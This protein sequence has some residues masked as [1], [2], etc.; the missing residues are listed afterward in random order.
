MKHTK[1]ILLL[2]F[3]LI[4]AAPAF[5]Q[6]TCEIERRVDENTG[7]TT[8][9]TSSA[10]RFEFLR[11]HVGAFGDGDVSMVLACQPGMLQM[12]I[13]V[14][15]LEDT[16]L[17][18]NGELRTTVDGDDGPRLRAIGS[19]THEEDGVYIEV[20]AFNL[21]E[22]QL[23]QLAVAEKVRFHLPAFERFDRELM[24]V[25]LNCLKSFLAEMEK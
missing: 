9:S 6:D 13:Y 11:V 20:L 4:T 1:W 8:L 15:S 17:D 24:P 25:H 7:V 14:V 12:G 18:G 10:F 23:R 5:A 21:T 19:Q 22:D 3:V 2:G 16:F